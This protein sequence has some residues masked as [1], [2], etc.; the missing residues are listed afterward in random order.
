V[1]ID[2]ITSDIDGDDDRGVGQD[3]ESMADARYWM[4]A[5]LEDWAD[6]Q[7]PTNP[8]IH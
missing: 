8:S 6:I 5:G 3:A 1:V 4:D 2:K 7:Y